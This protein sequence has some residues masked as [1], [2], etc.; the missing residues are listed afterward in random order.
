MENKQIEVQGKEIAIKNSFGDIAI[1]PI[2]KVEEVMRLIEEECWNCI[3]KLVAKL[4]TMSETKPVKAEAKKGV[5]VK[6]EKEETPPTKK[7]KYF[8]YNEADDQEPEPLK[9]LRAMYNEK[10]EQKLFTLQNWEMIDPED[11][12]KE[13]SMDN[14]KIAYMKS[15]DKEM[16]M[17]E[18]KYYSHKDN[19]EDDDFDR[20][21]M[22]VF[23]SKPITIDRTK[24]D[25]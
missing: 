17:I 21:K 3:D 23:Y 25:L 10:A 15:L 24:T 14:V 20:K 6:N 22:G 13:G 9:E 7:P 12:E 5:V 4:P 16:E 2:D 1:I 11:M 8:L 19:L 18:N